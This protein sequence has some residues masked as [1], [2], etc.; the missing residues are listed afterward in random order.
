M[1]NY[2]HHH[3]Y[4]YCYYYYFAVIRTTKQRKGLFWLAVHLGGSHGDK[5]E[6]AAGHI[7]SAV[8]KQKEMCAGAQFTFPVFFFFLLSLRHW[9]TGWCCS[10]LV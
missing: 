2:H 3:Y 1:E 6:A 7:A 5:H 4:C 9:H 8:R 10:H